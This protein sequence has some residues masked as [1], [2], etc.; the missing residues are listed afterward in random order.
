MPLL[1][2]PPD[3]GKKAPNTHRNLKFKYPYVATPNKLIS[4]TVTQGQRRALKNQKYQLAVSTLLE[5]TSLFIPTNV[6]L[7]QKALTPK[8]PTWQS[9]TAMVSI[10]STSL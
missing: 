3:T 2:Q 6:V 4:T 9:I 8:L 10:Q 5:P 7:E 1:L